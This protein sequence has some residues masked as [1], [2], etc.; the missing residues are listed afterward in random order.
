MEEKN[1]DGIYRTYFHEIYRFLLSLCY[2]HHTAEDLV[3]ETFFQAHLYVENYD[4]ENIKTWLF[5]VAHHAFIDYYRKQ[6]RTVIKEQSFFL[7]LF[8]KKRAPAETIVVQEEIQEIISMLK[9]LPDKHKFAVLLHDFHGL[10]Y[11][12]AAQV[13]NVPQ[14]HFKVLLFRGRQAIRR[15]KAGEK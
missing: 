12:E 4:G 3:Q 8:D 14:P 11:H 9:E 1:I 10:S 2:D 7:S 13:M 6:K 15:R 5:T